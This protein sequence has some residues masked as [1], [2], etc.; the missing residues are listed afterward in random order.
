MKHF[1]SIWMTTITIVCLGLCLNTDERIIPPTPDTSGAEYKQALLASIR[2]ATRI[3]V[4]EHSHPLD[5][6]YFSSDPTI[7]LDTSEH[8]YAR[9]ALSNAQKHRFYVIAS[10]LDERTEDVFT[11]C[12]FVPH[13]TIQFYQGT[14]LQSTMD[15]CFH[16]GD[17]SWDHF[18]KR[19]PS[20][21]INGLRQFVREIGLKPKREWRI[22]AIE[23]SLSGIKVVGYPDP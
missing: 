20:S 5:Y 21:M 6:R 18:S 19:P 9:I 17:I 13:H 8:V 12:I 1:L 7:T 15:V 4:T 3:I 10:A 2:S 22:L 11:L 16:C 23:T 14:K